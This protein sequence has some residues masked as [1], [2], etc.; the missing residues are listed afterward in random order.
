M[1]ILVA[2]ALGPET[3]QLK[4]IT[5]APVD[6]LTTGLGTRRTRRTLDQHLASQR[7]DLLLFTGT[8]GQLNPEIPLGR[9]VFPET[10]LEQ[11]SGHSFPCHPDT[12]EKLAEGGLVPT[13][14]G[15]TVS[16]PVATHTARLQLHQ[17]TSADICDMEATAALAAALAAG[18]PAAAF[19][20]VSDT[21]DRALLHYFRTFRTCMRQLAGDLEQVVGC[22]GQ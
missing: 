20:V 21:G 3:R 13:G 10:W 18:V 7:V 16:T 8:A 2:C 11:D 15:L 9:T 1:Q 6:W 4:R 22:L 12:L 5:Q 14:T 17:S 19:K